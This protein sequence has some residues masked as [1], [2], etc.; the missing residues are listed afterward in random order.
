MFAY[1]HSQIAAHTHHHK[2]K[3]T[4]NTSTRQIKDSK[5]TTL[6]Q[7]TPKHEPQIRPKMTEEIGIFDINHY[8]SGVHRKTVKI[9]QDRRNTIKRQMKLQRR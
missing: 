6:V 8:I 3:N 7:Q 2:H 4:N 1:C 5:P 9:R